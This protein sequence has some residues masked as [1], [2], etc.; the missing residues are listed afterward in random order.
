MSLA[1]CDYVSR[2]V[3]LYGSFTMWLRAT[4]RGRHD[5]ALHVHLLRAEWDSQC[6]G[7]M[8]KTSAEE[9]F[10]KCTMKIWRMQSCNRIF[11]GSEQYG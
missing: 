7:S 9:V 10:D 4:S 1:M 2:W 6:S 11:R 3:T 8:R 5:V